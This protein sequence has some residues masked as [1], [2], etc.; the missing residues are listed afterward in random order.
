MAL[1]QGFGVLHALDHHCHVLH[2]LQLHRVQAVPIGVVAK[3]VGGVHR[4]RAVQI[5][6]QMLGDVAARFQAGNGVQDGLRPA[7]RKHRDDHHTRARGG[8]L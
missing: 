7:H 6:G 2:G 8:A 3:Q 4:H 5:N 1:G